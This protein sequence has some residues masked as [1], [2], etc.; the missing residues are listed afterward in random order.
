MNLRRC[1]QLPGAVAVAAAVLVAAPAGNSA[2]KL[3]SQPAP[4]S[5]DCAG[6]FTWDAIWR[7]D[8]SLIPGSQGYICT[9]PGTG[10][11]GTATEDSLAL[12]AASHGW[13][14]M[15]TRVYGGRFYLFE[16]QSG[17]D[18]TLYAGYGCEWLGL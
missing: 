7:F 8:T 1:V 9:F 6:A 10:A 13:Q 18:T 4:A 15:C 3:R 17:P 12:N 11:G 2:P 5:G 14:S 16:A